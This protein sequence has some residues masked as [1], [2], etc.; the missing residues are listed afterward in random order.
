[1]WVA[2]ARRII[3]GGFL[4]SAGGVLPKLYEA[5]FLYVIRGIYQLPDVVLVNI[6]KRRGDTIKGAAIKCLQHTHVA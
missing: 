3:E 2:K 4:R 5:D 6:W 1:M